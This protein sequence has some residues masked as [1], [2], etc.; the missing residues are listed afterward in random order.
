MN[1]KERL[2]RL[3]RLDELL[4]SKLGCQ[5]EDEDDQIDQEIRKFLLSLI[6]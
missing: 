6:Q 3:E 1:D 2:E 4:E 5:T